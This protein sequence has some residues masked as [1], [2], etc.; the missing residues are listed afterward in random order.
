MKIK[1]IILVFF[2]KKKHTKMSANTEEVLM[3]DSAAAV[4][5]I[6]RAAPASEIS[7]VARDQQRAMAYVQFRQFLDLAWEQIEADAD[8]IG[9]TLPGAPPPRPRRS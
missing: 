2:I 7:L 5:E 9:V 6:Q 1:G 3:L 8:K 4:G